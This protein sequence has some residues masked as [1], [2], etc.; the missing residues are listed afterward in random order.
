M[1]DARGAREATPRGYERSLF[2]PYLLYRFEPLRIKL[3]PV[4]M[5]RRANVWIPARGPFHFSR[6]FRSRKMPST[7]RPESSSKRRSLT[8]SPRAL[9]TFT[10]SST[11]RRF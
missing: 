11:V 6:L 1:T 3:K 4:H 7:P 8:E 5:L 9:A 2:G 10:R